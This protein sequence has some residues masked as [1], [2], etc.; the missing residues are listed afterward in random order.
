[1]ITCISTSSDA[2]V[3]IIAA[4]TLGTMEQ[5]AIV[6]PRQGIID[7]SIVRQTVRTLSVVGNELANFITTHTNDNAIVGPQVKG[8]L[9]LS[10]GSQGDILR[11][12]IKV[13]GGLQ[14]THT[15]IIDIGLDLTEMTAVAQ[16]TCQ[17]AWQRMEGGVEEETT[18]I[19]T[20]NSVI[21]VTGC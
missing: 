6:L 16:D 7:T 17:M 8:H 4:I 2:T 15:L 9:G 5:L 10:L 11:R 13:T 12:I 19:G 18:T 20:A 3:D 14:M 1:M 21:S